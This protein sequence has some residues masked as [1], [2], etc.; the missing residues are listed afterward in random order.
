MKKDVLNGAILIVA[1]LI[2]T[3][4]IFVLAPKESPEEQEL[5]EYELDMP[6]QEEI[7]LFKR[8]Y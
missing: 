4:M 2:T 7:E 6:T 5:R 1:M 3:L 8:F